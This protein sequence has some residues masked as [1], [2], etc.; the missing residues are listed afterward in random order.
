MSKRLGKRRKDR[1]YKISMEC[2]GLGLKWM[3]P[4]IREK[5]I[6]DYWTEEKWLEKLKST[7]LIG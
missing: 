6:D 3:K 1:D 7:V 5:P 4:G 2:K